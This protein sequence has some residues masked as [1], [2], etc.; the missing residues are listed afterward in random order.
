V[1]AALGSSPLQTVHM[2]IRRGP[3]DVRF[4]PLEL[5]E[6]GEQRDLDVVVDPEHMVLD[7]H[8][9]RMIAQFT[10]KRQIIETLTR[11]SERD[12]ATMTASRRVHLHFYQAPVRLEGEGA[13][14]T[15]VT[16]RTEP[17]ELGRVRGTGELTRTPVQAVY[18]AVGYASSP[19]PG[20][21]FD[22]SRR[23]VPNDEGRV[24]DVEGR[25]IPGLYVTGW[26]K[27]GPVGLIG[28]TKSDARQTVDN[29]IL[30][31]AARHS[32]GPSARQDI[33]DVLD[34]RSIGLMSWED[35]LRVDA[36]ELTAGAERGRQRIKI[37][38]RAELIAA[39]R[40]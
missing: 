5:R 19:V 20:V 34:Q 40:A 37:V 14:A 18:R 9:R 24:L 39:A 23:V 11:W 22:G 13:V 31:L 12:P 35:W 28:S 4:S 33:E 29:M 21:P 8:A 38:T 6:L 3:V 25:A 2:F 10:P 32:A 16:E 26:I 27:R 17:D 15:I 1:H 30:D 36:A 7:D